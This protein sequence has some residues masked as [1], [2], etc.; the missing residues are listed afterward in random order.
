[1]ELKNNPIL[2]QRP[3]MKVYNEK[4]LTELYQYSKENG[5][6]DIWTPQKK[7]QL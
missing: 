1:V 7:I 6:T 3:D 5:F 4:K 2:N